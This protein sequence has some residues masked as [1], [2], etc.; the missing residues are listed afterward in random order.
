MSK[1]NNKTIIGINLRFKFTFLLNPIDIGWKC[2]FFAQ[3]FQCPLMIVMWKKVTQC[4]F[5]LR[6]LYTLHNF[7]NTFLPN[8]R[9]PKVKI[10]KSYKFYSQPPKILLPKKRSRSSVWS[11][12]CLAPFF[13]RRNE[14]NSNNFVK[15]S[16]LLAGLA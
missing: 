4:I 1:W 15:M 11:F 3:I 9:V 7:R 16:M 8:Y 5:K 10:E 2:P 6:F 13:S 14:T 12:K